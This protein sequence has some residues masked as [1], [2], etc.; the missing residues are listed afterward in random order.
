MP[1]RTACRLHQP[2]G[3]LPA[4]PAVHRRTAKRTP[5][6]LGRRRIGYRRPRCEPHL[7]KRPDFRFR[8]GVCAARNARAEPRAGRRGQSCRQSRRCLPGDRRQAR[9]AVHGDRE[10]DQRSGPARAAAGAGPVNGHPRLRDEQRAAQSGADGCG[11]RRLAGVL[12]LP[13]RP[14]RPQSGRGAARRRSRPGRT[15]RTD[16]R[17]HAYPGRAGRDHHAVRDRLR[18]DRPAVGNGSD[19]RRRSQT[20]DEVSFTFGGIAV[21]SRDV[22]YEGAAPCCAGLYQFAVRLPTVVP[23]G[24]AAVMATVQGVTTPEGPFLA[25]RR[26]Q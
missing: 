12:Q 16:S 21:P 5:H 14:R 3:V 24:N 20:R 23:D 17:R 13:G 10:S 26:Q 1:D 15:A 8:A 19:S 11:C 7:P 22:L 4:Y 18:R 6:L 25:V 9:A 2:F